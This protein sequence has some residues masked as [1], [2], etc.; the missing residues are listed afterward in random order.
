[1]LNH[2]DPLAD[3]MSARRGSA[4]FA[5]HRR[6]AWAA[7]VVMSM[8]VC[9]V[10]MGCGASD[11]FTV[12]PTEHMQPT[13][14]A[15]TVE[16][17][18]ACAKEGAGRLQRHSYEI[19]FEVHLSEDGAVRAVWPKGAQLDDSGLE[20]CLMG[21]LRAMSTSGQL[22]DEMSSSPISHASRRVI[23]TSALLPALVELAP[24]IITGS[25]V[26]IIV[27]VGILVLAAVSM[28]YDKPTK[29]ECDEQLE[30]AE[31]YCKKA[32][33]RRNPPLEVVGR[34]KDFDECVQNNIHEDC[35]GKKVDREKSPRPGR[36]Y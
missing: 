1:M 30:W 29:E 13:L 25:G 24:V 17:L 31:D 7:L 35:G 22:L 12:V 26:T 9:L 16:A 33:R 14:P 21:A 36:R 32:L 34:N 10:P 6:F 28:S 5:R 20:A 2:G 19:G 3:G 15:S 23:G 27:M 8:A 4:A 11:D 18:A